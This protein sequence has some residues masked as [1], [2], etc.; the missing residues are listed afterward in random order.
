[1]ERQGRIFDKN[2][3]HY[4]GAHVVAKHPTMSVDELYGQFIKTWKEFFAM[5][6]HQHAGAFEPLTYENGRNIV[7]IPLQKK[8]VRNHAV[9]TGM[10]II[11]PVGND[12]ETVTKALKESRSGLGPITKFDTSHFRSDIGGEIRQFKPE[13]H[14]GAEEIKDYSD[15]YIQ[16]AIA[17]ARNAIKDSGLEFDQNT[18][19]RNVALVLGTCNGG[20]LSAEE[21]YKWKH[22]KSDLAFNERLNL[23]AQ[24]YGFGKAMAQTLGIGGEI[25]LAT[26]ACSATTGAIGIAQMLINRGYYDTVLVGGS[27]SLCVANISGFNGLKATA[28]GHTAPFSVPPGLNT[29]EA[30]C[31][32]VVEEMEK[33][34]LRHARCYGK[35]V[36]HA[37]TSDAYHP[38][39]PDP[40]GDG[41]YRTLRNALDDSQVELSDIGCINAHGT[42][43]EANDRSETRGIIKF[44]GNNA[45]PVI[46]LKSFFGHCMGSTGIL[47]ATCN[48]LGMNNDFIPPT[49]NFS[50]PRPGCNLDYVPN[51]PRK[52]EYNAFISANYAFGGNNAAIVLSKW[53]HIV[54]PVECKNKKVVITGTG[55]VSALGLGTEN[56]VRALKN[57]NRGLSKI[58]GLNLNNMKSQLAGFVP[59]FRASD[60]DR[61]LDLSGMNKISSIATAASSLALENAGLRVNRRNA[62]DFGIVMGVCNGPNEMEHMDSVFSSDNYT[63]DLNSFSNITANSTAGWVSNALCLKGV[64]MTLSPG[65]HAGLQSLAYAYDFLSDGRAKSILA[66]AADEVYAQAYFN[67]NLLN[68]LFQG[69]DE[70]D[71]KINLSSKKRKVLGEGSAVIVTET[72]ESAQERN[73][74]ILAEITGYGMSMDAGSF[75]EQNLG[76]EGL[77]H[78]CKTAMERSGIEPDNINL[79]VWAPQGNIQ[80]KKVL[81]ALQNVLGQHYNNVPFGA[82]T[83]NTGFIESAT[84]LTTLGA[85]LESL[86]NDNTLWPQITGL[87]ELDER[88]LTKIPEYILALGS[89]DIG[90]NFAVVLRNGK[91]I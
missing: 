61:R 51:K 83:F 8:G 38:T 43:T 77:E 9:I 2:W 84:I 52:K 5:K 55:I 56:T 81:D 48:I 82:T 10:G 23:Q 86:N 22:N 11:S 30:A 32:W 33:A 21:E 28:T 65:P 6:K 20:L 26:T 79:I 19:K 71:Y 35:I 88:E 49:I 12:P 40:R 27:D 17:A 44:Q 72:L 54:K 18:V 50:E 53:D 89:T 64:S 29:G 16:Y 15:A 37:T 1:L 7:G 73:A 69:E 13:E 87:P 14:L 47:E 31:F 74:R 70:T 24:Y 67:Y 41:A 78:A 76:S 60:V 91:M 75:S 90:Y 3:S 36:G 4:N 59:E 39:A 58:T 66:G 62:G 42:G 25:W 63:S 80:D 57:K 34:I 68:F 85:T 45:I 46:S